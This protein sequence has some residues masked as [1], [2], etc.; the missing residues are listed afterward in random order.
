[1]DDVSKAAHRER[2]QELMHFINSRHRRITE[3]DEKLVKKLHDGVKVSDFFLEF[4][5]KS[6]VMINIEK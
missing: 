5:F 1:M 6:G 2:I 4:K 3:F